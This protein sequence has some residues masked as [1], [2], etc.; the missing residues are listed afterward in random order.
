VALLSFPPT[1]VNGDV[2]PAV[3]VVGQNQYKWSSADQVW[4][5]LGVATGVVPG[6]YGT[7]TKVGQFQVNTSGEI[8]F[9]QNVNIQ[10]ATTTQ[11][12][13][14][15]I[16]TNAE[17]LAGFNAVS[18]VTP[19]ALQSKTSSS[20][21]LNSSTNLASSAAVFAV[22]TVANAAIPKSVVTTKGDIIVATGPSAP[23]RLGVGTN[24]Q[25]L[26]ADSTST[27]GMVWAD[28]YS[29]KYVQFD[30]ISTFFNGLT[31]SFQLKVNG[32]ATAPTPSTNIMVFLGGIAQTPGA[33]NAY[34]VSGV[35]INFS[36]PPP[37]GA[38]FYATTVA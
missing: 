30:D 12:G 26:T 16:A 31:S 8:V 15:E 3:P 23:T 11:V 5:L 18:A 2:Y 22:A 37:I 25:L 35:T 29:F 14:I 13:L 9:A 7:S 36:A 27:A 4:R 6:T 17:T 33:G 1:P 20:T 10:L 38:T 24:G 32:A 34:T 19:F 28:P 21:T